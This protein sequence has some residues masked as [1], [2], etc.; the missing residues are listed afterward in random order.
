MQTRFQ[1]EAEAE[2]A[3]AREWYALQRHGLDSELMLRID[4]TLRHITQAPEAY[5]QI[6]RQIRRAVIRQFPFAIFYE[7][8]SDE[9]RVIAVYHS[10]RN[11]KGWK[12]RV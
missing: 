3:E 10:K 9:I 12:S 2:L 11:P 4:E 7:Q 6:Y 1:P 5:P 8:K